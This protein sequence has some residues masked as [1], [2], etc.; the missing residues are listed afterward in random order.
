[1]AEGIFVIESDGTLSELTEQPYDSEDRLQALLATYP[2]LLAGKQM[3]PV[4]P[5]KWLL[6][7]REAPVPDLL[8]GSGRWS[9]DHLFLDQEGIP[10]L[11][12]VKRSSDTRIRREV[13][14]QMLDYAANGVVY[15]PVALIKEQFEANCRGRGRDAAAELTAFLGPDRDP[16][17][18]WVQ[19]GRNLQV[20]CVRLVFVADEIPEELRRIVEFLNEQM[21]ETE[22]LAVEI[23]QF[24]GG[25]LR[26]LVPR[27]IG[28]TATAEQVK[29]PRPSRQWD[30]GAF[31]AALREHAGEDA[32][33]GARAVLDWGRRRGVGV[34][35]GRGAQD[36]SFLL[37]L[38]D[39][40]VKHWFVS[41]W[42]YGRME[43][44]FQYMKTSGPFVEES[45]REEFRSRLNR[46]EGFN[47]GPDALTQRPRLELAKLKDPARQEALFSALDWELAEVRKWQARSR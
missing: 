18:F 43:A 23:R 33:V 13:V 42:T 12:E 36:G 22:V 30:E 47:I 8:G 29:T 35:W 39:G 3:D 19:V 34:W 45:L 16:D 21:K 27:V 17:A 25:T 5:R 46:V 24:V 2:D 44:L 7:T 6:V 9:V 4:A 32:V 31:L 14:G 20:R 28:R 11:V 38:L 37:W 1:M 40:D 15:W 10:T 26:T 41:C